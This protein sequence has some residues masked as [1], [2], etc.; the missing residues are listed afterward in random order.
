MG[1]CRCYPCYE[2]GEIV[3]MEHVGDTKPRSPASKGALIQP[4]TGRI[5]GKPKWKCP[6]CGWTR[7][8]RGHSAADMQEE[9][10]RKQAYT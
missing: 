2:R 7:V 4:F 5:L 8:G 10:K 3:W 6:K 9:M 1:S